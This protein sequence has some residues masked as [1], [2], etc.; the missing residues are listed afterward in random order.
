[1][2]SPAKLYPTFK[3]N[4]SGYLWLQTPN[5]KS[6]SQREPLQ[7]QCGTTHELWTEAVKKVRSLG[8]NERE[9]QQVMGQVVVQFGQHAGE[10]SLWL[11][12]NCLCYAAYNYGNQHEGRKKV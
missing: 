2:A 5:F 7:G 4:P 8:G 9:E 10:T 12:D 6:V 3:R 1:M 11:V